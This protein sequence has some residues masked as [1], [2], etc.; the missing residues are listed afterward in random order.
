MYKDLIRKDSYTFSIV[1]LGPRRYTP[2]SQ[3]GDP[4]V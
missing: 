1:N 4:D 3:T 2:T